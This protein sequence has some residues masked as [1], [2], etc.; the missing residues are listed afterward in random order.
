MSVPT[1]F[2]SV[3]ITDMQSTLLTAMVDPFASP[4]NLVVILI[5]SWSP[6]TSVVPVSPPPQIGAWVP[7]ESLTM[8]PM[9]ALFVRMGARDHILSGQS[10]FFVELSETAAML[11][12]ATARSLVALDELGR[13]TATL[14]GGCATAGLQPGTLLV[15]CCHCVLHS[16]PLPATSQLVCACHHTMV[17]PFSSWH[18]H[19]TCEGDAESVTSDHAFKLLKRLCTVAGAAIAAAVLDH[20]AHQ[21]GCCGLFATHYHQLAEA[22][23][24]DPTVS[25]MHMACAVAEETSEGTTQPGVQEVT[26]LYKLTPGACARHDMACAPCTVK[27]R[28]CNFAWLLFFTY[29]PTTAV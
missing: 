17:K 6:N 8:F 27:F 20:L 3:S 1:Y 26:F 25:I 7:A 29:K 2:C 16:L 10:T 4:T 12:R 14:D 21:T 19:A 24:S 13:G 11:Q 15:I 9:D 28:A 18:V 5:S 23:D 22:H